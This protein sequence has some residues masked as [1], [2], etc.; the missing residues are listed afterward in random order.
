MIF[1]TFQDN[2]KLEE[3][4]EITTRYLNGKTVGEL[5]NYIK[6]FG[7]GYSE[8]TLFKSIMQM[9][10]IEEEEGIRSKRLIKNEDEIMK[11]ES[12]FKKF[13][14]TDVILKFANLLI[15]D[16]IRPFPLRDQLLVVSWQLLVIE[17]FSRLFSG[18]IWV[19]IPEVVIPFHVP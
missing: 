18:G 15:Y 3:L 16:L 14:V 12:T 5:Y 19:S 4:G 10:V 8:Y 13:Q 1:N 6:K 9:I 7:H 17:S 11:W 2:D